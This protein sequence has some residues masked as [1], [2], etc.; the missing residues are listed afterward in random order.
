MDLSGITDAV[1]AF[2]RDNPI[3]AAAAGLFSLYLLFRRTKLFFLLL[4]LGLVLAA[5]LYFI[6]DVASIGKAEKKQMIEKGTG[7]GMDDIR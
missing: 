3:T 7:P 2:C 4:F 6:M 1:T 5:A